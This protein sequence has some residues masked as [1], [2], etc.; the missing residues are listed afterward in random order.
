MLS[1][2]I[3]VMMGLVVIHVEVQVILIGLHVGL[4]LR[5]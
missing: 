2:S 4:F 3:K 5:F 1:S